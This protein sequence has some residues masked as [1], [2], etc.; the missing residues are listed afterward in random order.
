LLK[1][2]Y[3]NPCA[4]EILFHP[5][6]PCAPKD[7]PSKLASKIGMLVNH[8]SADGSV[9]VVPEFLSGSRRYICRLFTV[10]PPGHRGNGSSVAVLL[11]RRPVVPLDVR[12]VCRQYHL[13]PREGQAIECLVQGLTSK[14]IADRM[15]I[16]PNTV[17]VFLRLAMVKM[18]ATSRS[19]LLSKFITGSTGPV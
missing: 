13:T 4:A 7:L 12:K 8:A 16:S 1:P 6:R 9:S 18:G 3:I 10:E 5:D 17:K 19:G 11:E 15:G 2:L 14:E